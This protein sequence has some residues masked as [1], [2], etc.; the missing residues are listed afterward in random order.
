M[1]K[2]ALHLPYDFLALKPKKLRKGDSLVRA[3]DNWDGGYVIPASVVSRIKSIVSYG[4][5]NNFSF[6]RD[7][8]RWHRNIP[9]HVYDHS[10]TFK[11]M[12]FDVLTSVRNLR[13]FENFRFKVSQ[14]KGRILYIFSYMSFFHFTKGVRHFRY[15]VV[16]DRES[17]E[18]I[19]ILETFASVGDGVL[20]KMD[21]EGGEYETILEIL[22]TPKSIEAICIEFHHVVTHR[23]KFIQIVDLLSHDFSIVHFHVNNAGRVFE[24]IP[25][26]L[27]LTFTKNDYVDSATIDTDLP[28]MSLDYANSP[29]KS[30]Y[31]V[32]F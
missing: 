12:L 20:L 16:R 1:D 30:D 5:G 28:L 22:N 4:L 32:I 27:E 11:S 21:I 2:I 24:N 29:G 26:I 17:I 15:E 7:I 25:D 6:E 31:R 18:Q 23:D 13:S 8:H 3:G 10:V 14:I 9:I 19:A